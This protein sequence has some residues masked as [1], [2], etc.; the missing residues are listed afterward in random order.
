MGY[1]FKRDESVTAGVRRIAREELDEV[2][3]QLSHAQPK[4]R[5]DAI[6]EA[7]K[8]VK[9]VRALLRLVQPEMGDAYGK[10]TRTLCDAGR[11][12]SELRDASS[13]IE[14]LEKLQQ[15]YPNELRRPVFDSVRRGLLTRKREREQRED[16]AAVLRKIATELKAAGKR[17][18]RWPLATEGFPALESGLEKMFR[19]SR[20][21]FSKAQK[22][23]TAE[24]YHEWRKRLKDHWYHIRVLEST[25][26]EVMQGYEAALKDVETWIG[27]DHNLELLRQ[28]LTAGPASFGGE[29]SAEAVMAVIDKKTEA[30]AR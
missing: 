21:A 14:S 10:E 9:K 3:A 30:A 27:D 5:D 15:G 24:N 28:L 17:A 1:R 20:G 2:V 12:L 13:V 4:D 25:W 11:K 7:R 19:K 16:V 6:H 26:T 23:P 29:K 8:S 18:K 22:R